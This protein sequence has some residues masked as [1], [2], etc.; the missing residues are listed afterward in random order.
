MTASRKPQQQRL[1]TIE[2]RLVEFG[3]WLNEPGLHVAAGW[4][5]FGK[6]R[7]EQENA[8]AHGDGIKPDIIV[9]DGEATMC[10]PDGG[11][12]ALAEQMGRE[13]ARDNRCRDI[14]DLLH[15]LPDHHRDVMKAT[16]VAPAR[17]V[18]RSA[19]AAAKLLGVTRDQYG[20]RKAALL[21][22]FEGAMFRVFHAEPTPISNGAVTPAPEN[23]T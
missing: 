9:I 14:L 6:I 19:R 21:G 7:E 10:R 22:W 5:I 23:T 4:S 15:Y 2:Y 16:Y 1:S 20:E 3:E 12:A 13:I 18:P 11:L 8:G 17:D